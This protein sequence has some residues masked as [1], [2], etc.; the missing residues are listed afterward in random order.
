[1]EKYQD[2]ISKLLECA[3]ACENC[4]TQCLK[5]D[6]VKMM[7]RCIALDRDCADICLQG[8]RLLQRESAIALQYLLLCEEVCRAC[9]EECKK[10]EHE[11]CKSCAE[12]CMACAELCHQYHNPIT[13]E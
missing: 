3:L 13:Q 10:H 1:M 11:H 2:L 6:D 7:S 9:A 8:A 5:E 12:A 4:A